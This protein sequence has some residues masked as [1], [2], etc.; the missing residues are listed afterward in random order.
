MGR[1]VMTSGTM[2]V[3]ALGRVE[4]IEIS[5]GAAIFAVLWIL[6]LRR[7]I[8]KRTHELV[9][10]EGRFRTLVEQVPTP[11]IVFEVKS[12]RIEEVNAEQCCIRC[13]AATASKGFERQ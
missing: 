5:V 3:L 7:Q 11:L 1:D 2:W 8:K 12:G 9:V 10:S 4:A 6:T 13:T